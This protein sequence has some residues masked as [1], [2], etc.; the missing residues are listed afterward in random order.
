[1]VTGDQPPTAAAIAHKV[2]IISDPE[3]EFN[4]ILK[5]NPGMSKDEAFKKCRAIVI[6]GD[7]LAK[8]HAREEALDDNE[9]EKGRRILDWIA[10]PEVVFARTTP[11]QKLLIVDA[12]QRSGHIVAVTGDGVNDS[13]AIKKAN[14]GVAM[15]SGSDVAQN[16]A[17]MILLNDDFSSIVNGVLEG[18]TLFENLKKSI[19]YTITHNIP[20]LAG[21]L[22]FI[23]VQIPLPLSAILCLCLDLGTDLWPAITFAYEY[24]ETDIMERPP[25]NSKRDGLVGKKLFC[26][27]YVFLG[28]TECFAAFFAFFMCMNDY[29]FRPGT[30]IGL[31]TEF[32]YYPKPTDVYNPNLPNNGNTNYGDKDY[33][34]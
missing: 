25:R 17:D 21:F 27:A 12:C 13:P 7:D 18:R 26:N 16:A 19:S 5:K 9:I 8:V 4:A 24:P 6:H 29:G 20:E 22:A 30:L 2:N 33:Y 10:K 3:M 28:P 23:V 34:S 32:G 11:S 14:I 15:G 1:M 31:G